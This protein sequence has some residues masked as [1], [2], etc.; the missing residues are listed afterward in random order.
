M[1]S[2]T[3]HVVYKVG[4]NACT[5]VAKIPKNQNNPWNSRNNYTISSTKRK[6]TL[7]NTV[8]IIEFE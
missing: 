5:M 8:L 1:L 3:F 2:P 4:D 7:L 6:T